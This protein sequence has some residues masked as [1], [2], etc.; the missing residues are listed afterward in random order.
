MNNKP[1]RDFVDDILGD[2]LASLPLPSEYQYYK[3]LKNNCIVIND[4]IDESIIESACIP[5]L[6]MDQDP[7]VKEIT[8]YLT[9]CGGSTFYGFALCDIIDR[10]TTPTTVIV[11]GVCASMG[12]LIAMSGHNNPNVYVKA[13]KST[14]GLIHS[15]SQYLEGN[16]HSVKDTFEFNN[17]YEEYIKQYILSH[18][19]IDSD[20]YDKIERYE[21][22]M[23]ADD[24]LKHEIINEII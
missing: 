23:T 1:E 13:Y 12:C 9:S 21:Y 15:G 6:E 22:W 18:T 8:I 7:K 5:L 24:M 10:L 20:L 11:I 14:V 2:G 19:T 3:H 17:R 4:T 16:T